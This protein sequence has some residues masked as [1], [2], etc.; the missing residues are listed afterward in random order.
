M[1]PTTF[2]KYK[3]LAQ[4]LETR[5]P[6]PTTTIN[7]GLRHLEEAYKKIIIGLI[8]KLVKNAWNYEVEIRYKETEVR[9]SVDQHGNELRHTLEEGRWVLSISR[10][11]HASYEFNYED[12]VA[13]DTINSKIEQWLHFKNAEELLTRGE[14]LIKFLEGF[15]L[16]NNQSEPLD[17]RH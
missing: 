12:G 5:T 6:L 14:K 3:T 11:L 1:T 7:Y 15:T 13:D 17:V 9:I 8:S 10:N 16:N 4:D 2:K